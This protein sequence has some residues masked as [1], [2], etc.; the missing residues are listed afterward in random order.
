M[1]MIFPRGKQQKKKIEASREVHFPIHQVRLSSELNSRPL[2]LSV[3]RLLFVPA[4]SFCQRDFFS[5][6]TFRRRGE[7]GGKAELLDCAQHAFC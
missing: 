3:N 1:V 4:N 7:K 6:K 5:T 2:L